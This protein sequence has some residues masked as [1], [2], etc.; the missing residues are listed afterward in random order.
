MNTWTKLIEGYFRWFKKKG[1]NRSTVDANIIC[2]RYTYILATSE[3]FLVM[4]PKKHQNFWSQVTSIV[5][6]LSLRLFPGDHDG[7]FSV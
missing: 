7:A 3:W 5:S 6:L 1:D 4:Y 2:I